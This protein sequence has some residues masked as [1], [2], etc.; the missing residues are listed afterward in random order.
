MYRLTTD[1]FTG[2]S[3]DLVPVHFVSKAKGFELPHD[4]RGGFV[5]DGADP[6][7]LLAAVRSTGA[8]IFEYRVRL[9]SAEVRG[10]GCSR[11]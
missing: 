10:V 7:I 3:L 5:I 4:I 8:S 2:I 6:D 1:L 11:W 9:L